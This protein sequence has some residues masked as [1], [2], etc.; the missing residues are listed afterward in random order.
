MFTADS[1]PTREGV[2]S[3]LKAFEATGL[4]PEATK[5]NPGGLI[6]THFV[7]RAL[8]MSRWSG[9]ARVPFSGRA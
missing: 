5:M 2:M 9:R 1:L 3:L 8:E 6:D 4:V 7:H